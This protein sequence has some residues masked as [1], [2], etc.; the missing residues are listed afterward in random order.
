[1]RVKK[2]SY[3]EINSLAIISNYFLEHL[4]KEVTKGK[5]ALYLFRRTYFEMQLLKN[6]VTGVSM[7]SNPTF[8]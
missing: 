1:M 5:T 3:A 6:I 7:Y 2:G 4:A 8:S